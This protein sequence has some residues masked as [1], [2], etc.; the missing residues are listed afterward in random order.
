MKHFS[1]GLINQS[2]SMHHVLAWYYSHIYFVRWICRSYFVKK[3]E[4]YLLLLSDG[5]LCSGSRRGGCENMCKQKHKVYSVRCKTHPRRRPHNFY[6]M[7]MS[8][9][10]IHFNIIAHQLTVRTMMYNYYTHFVCTNNTKH[11]NLTFDIQ[12]TT[13]TVKSHSVVF[14][15]VTIGFS[16]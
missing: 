6:L 7:S 13:Y 9:I 1:S 5:L 3:N 12:M 16:F 4:H 2:D 14:I 8:T 11:V 10:H 15:C